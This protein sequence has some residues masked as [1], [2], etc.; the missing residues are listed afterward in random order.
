VAEP[1]ARFPR[2]RPGGPEPQPIPSGG[3]TG[4]AK[5][6]GGPLGPDA[7]IEKYPTAPS[8][9]RAGTL[10][11]LREGSQRDSR[12]DR[13]YTTSRT[14]STGSRSRFA[15]RSRQLPKYSLSKCKCSGSTATTPMRRDSSPGDSTSIVK[16]IESL[17][18]KET[19]LRTRSRG[20]G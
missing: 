17:E 7:E 3:Q 12:G 19:A 4:L 6:V 1:P 14:S 13:Q 5:G 18:E 10:T 20:H 8:A 2:A 16:D 9:P 15:A 11:A